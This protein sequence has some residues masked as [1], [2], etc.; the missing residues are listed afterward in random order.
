MA[1]ALSGFSVYER[2]FLFRLRGLIRFSFCVFSVSCFLF[3][4]W[5]LDS[6]AF[7]FF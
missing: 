5:I 7:D 2:L 1:D 3:S 4:L 6:A